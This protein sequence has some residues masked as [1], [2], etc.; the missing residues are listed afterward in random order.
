[1]A[2]AMDTVTQRRGRPTGLYSSASSFACSD[3][4]VRTVAARRA[5]VRPAMVGME[6]DSAAA[7]AAPTS[8]WGRPES[9]SR[10]T[11]AER[12]SPRCGSVEVAG[13]PLPAASPSGFSPAGPASAGEPSALDGTGA[14]ASPALGAAGDPPALPASSVF[15]GASTVFAAPNV[16]PVRRGASPDTVAV[17]VEGDGAGMISTAAVRTSSVVCSAISSITT[18]TLSGAPASRVRST[19]SSTHSR[20]FLVSRTVRSTTWPAT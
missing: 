10:S 20:R 5:M 7:A 1:M 13:S 14:A 11:S 15:R 19:S 17:T 18:V 8:S 16:L 6:P 3:L 12:C 2:A 9:S 4:W